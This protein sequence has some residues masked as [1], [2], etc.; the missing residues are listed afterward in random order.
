MLS[1]WEKAVSSED[2]VKLEKIDVETMNAR[3][4]LHKACMDRREDGGLKLESK[5]EWI[6][7]KT[8]RRRQTALCHSAS[9]NSS[10]GLAAH[11]HPTS[12]LV[13]FT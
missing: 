13:H 9:G 12:H 11:D 6:E 3:T 7:F 10:W 2:Q 1:K 4:W 8:R 5:I